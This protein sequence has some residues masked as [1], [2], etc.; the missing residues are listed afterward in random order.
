MASQHSLP[1][2]HLSPRAL[3]RTWIVVAACAFLCATVPAVF[4]AVNGSSY[5]D[6]ATGILLG[7]MVFFVLASL[8]TILFGITRCC[9][10]NI[11]AKKLRMC[12]GAEFFGVGLLM[13]G[14][15]LLFQS[16]RSLAVAAGLLAAELCVAIILWYA[17]TTI[18]I[19]GRYSPRFILMFMG[20][21]GGFF[22][23]PVML[24]V[25]LFA[26]DIFSSLS[27]DALNHIRF[28]LF[29]TVGCFLISV[30]YSVFAKTSS[31][32]RKRPYPRLTFAL[33]LGSSLILYMGLLIPGLYAYNVRYDKSL[34]CLM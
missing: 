22:F 23:I 15:L 9:G 13:F 8:L 30:A 6:D 17:V 12:C 16:A 31:R 18:I 2:E 25:P 27:G 26:G 20:G 5:S 19:S 10:A 28:V 29:S 11:R 33:L 4:L 32:N 3:K 1:A 7:L 21:C 14:M 24:L 34:L